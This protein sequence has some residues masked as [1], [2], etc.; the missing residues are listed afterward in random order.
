MP[1][2]KKYIFICENMR[3][4]AHPKGCCGLKNGPELKKQL[5]LKLAEKGLNKVFRANTAGC[6]DMCEHGAVMA[7]YP[8]GIWYGKVTLQDLDEIIDDTLQKDRV[9]DRLLIKDEA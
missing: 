7:I 9:I 2:Y 5:K 4:P 1:S 3:D 6:L 8:Q